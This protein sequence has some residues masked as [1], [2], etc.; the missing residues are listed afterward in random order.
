VSFVDHQIGRV[1]DALDHSP[2]AG[3]TIVVLW[4]DHGWALG[5]K[6]RWA[7]RAL[8]QRETGV[9]LIVA[10]P[11][12]ARAVTTKKPAGLIDIYPTLVEL[13]GLPQY[14]QLEGNS[15]VRLLKDPDTPWDRP[16]LCTFWK[17][18]HAVISEQWRYIRYA[19]GSVELYK[20]QDDPHEWENLAG[21]SRYRTEIRRLAAYLPKVD[22]DPLPGS[23]GLGSALKDV[24]D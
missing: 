2:Y 19:D 4:G 23:H 13:C 15:L 21:D 10:A 9:P 20:T 1:L 6:Q 7:K 18:N 8:W 14:P 3:N 16:T 5:E 11:G 22:A 24:P 12:M 17:N